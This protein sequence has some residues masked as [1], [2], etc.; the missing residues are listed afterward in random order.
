[1]VE[2]KKEENYATIMPVETIQKS[3][4][5]EREKQNQKVEEARNPASN[6]PT[7]PAVSDTAFQQSSASLQ[8]ARDKLPQYAGTYDAQVNDAYQQ[9][10]NRDKF[11]YDLDAD[12]LYQQMRDEYVNL[13]QLA[14]RD[15]MGQAAALTG[16]YGSSYGQGVGQQQYNAY[17][18]TLN[19]QI[20]DLY[21]MALNQYTQEGDDLYRQY[22]MAQDMASTEYNRYQTDLDRYWQ[23]VDYEAGREESAYNRQQDAYGNLQEMILGTGYKPSPEQLAAAGM[24]QEEADSLRLTWAKG[25]PK[26]ALRAGDISQEEYYILTGKKKDSSSST[27]SSV[28]YTGPTEDDVRKE[29]QDR[30]DAGLI[31][32]ADYQAILKTLK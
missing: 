1:M 24:T 26:A 13:G 31:D 11:R 8:A 21:G 15:S 23:N 7:A 9:I 2:R 22:G 14:M 30:F 29:A 3:K 28:S 32:Y 18:K 25:D 4:D 12:M 6:S 17:L 16:G 5:A 27:S 20:P 10:V 19:E